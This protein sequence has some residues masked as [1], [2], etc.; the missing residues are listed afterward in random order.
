MEMAAAIDLAEHAGAEVDGAND[1]CVNGSELSS[2]RI[3]PDGGVGVSKQ[4]AGVIVRLVVGI[5]LELQFFECAAIA[6]LS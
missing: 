4:V 2:L 3:D 6:N 1:C 5:R